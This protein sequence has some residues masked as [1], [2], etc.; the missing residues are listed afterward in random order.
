MGRRENDDST[1]GPPPDGASDA[2]TDLAR[3]ALNR[4][5]D[6]LGESTGLRRTG[7]EL[8]QPSDL[9]QHGRR[10]A[11]PEG[12][13]A[14]ARGLCAVADGLLSAAARRLGEMWQ[15]DELS[16]FEVSI[17]V[18]LI[19]RLNHDHAQRHVPIAREPDL[20]Q[21]VF[22]TLPGQAHNL[23]LVLA[24]EAFRQADW[25]VTLLLDC[26]TG[27]IL[28][29]VRRLRPEIGGAERQQSRPHAPG[30]APDRD[31][32]ALPVRSDPAGRNGGRARSTVRCHRPRAWR[33]SRHPD[34]ARRVFRRG[35]PGI[36][37]QILPK[38]VP[39]SSVRKASGR[40]R[41]PVARADHGAERMGRAA[42]RLSAASAPW[43]DGDG[44]QRQLPGQ[45]RG[46][47][48]LGRVAGDIADQDDLARR[49]GWP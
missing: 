38:A 12:R 2:I 16:F 9:G 32:Q 33:S 18:S 13:G 5:A 7:R 4:L 10:G 17:A 41:E 27:V 25:Q 35:Q 45:D 24:A 6:R 29:R 47:E 42:A 11:C 26:A 39:A 14:A 30:G 49:C 43:A 36:A 46:Q 1:G 48:K 3:Q 28:D 34:G 22:A 15:R 31:L 44:P 8:L 21:A 23:G 19:F 37:I 40:V 20:R